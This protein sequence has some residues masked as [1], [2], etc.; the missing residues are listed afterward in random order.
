MDCKYTPASDPAQMS[1]VES[2][3][4]PF[5]RK[6]GVE[7][8]QLGVQTPSVAAV[9][10]PP[11]DAM[12]PMSIRGKSELESRG[13]GWFCTRSM[14]DVTEEVRR[15]ASEKNSIVSNRRGERAYMR[16]ISV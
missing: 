3:V 8:V 12:P 13:S 11:D 10:L 1:S 6:M 2:K 4:V 9:M 14:E 7:K 16:P 5:L 15:M